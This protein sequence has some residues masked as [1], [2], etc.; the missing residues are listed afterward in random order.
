MC[1]RTPCGTASWALCPR[2][3]SLLWSAKSLKVHQPPPPPH[4]MPTPTCHIISNNSCVP[5]HDQRLFF[6]PATQCMTILLCPNPC[7]RLQVPQESVF[8]W[9]LSCVCPCGELSKK[10]CQLL[11]IKKSIQY[12]ILH[13]FPVGSTVL[14]DLQAS[15]IMWCKQWSSS[16]TASS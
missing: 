9:L 10:P 1:L 13:E 3:L 7:V 6:N 5:S 16:S 15:G 11:P 12:T 14:R 4:N 2:R 8:N